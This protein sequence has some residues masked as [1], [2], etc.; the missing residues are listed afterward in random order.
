MLVLE[1][2]FFNNE[3]IVLFCFVSSCRVDGLPV[4]TETIAD[5]DL[6]SFLARAEDFEEGSASNASFKTRHASCMH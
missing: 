6:L 3:C 5:L 1:I 4:V 2:S